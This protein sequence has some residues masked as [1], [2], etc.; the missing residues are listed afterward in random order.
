V[1]ADERRALLKRSQAQEAR[2]AKAHGGTR[3]AGSG[4]GW[5]RKADVRAGRFLFENKICAGSK[6]ITIKL[7]DLR[8]VAQQAAA[9][10][11]T[12]VLQFDLGGHSYV[13]LTEDDFTELAG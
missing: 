4:N 6:Q 7:A 5:A 13:V 8:L 2:T 9:E 10:G 12:G 11:R 1:E 3:N